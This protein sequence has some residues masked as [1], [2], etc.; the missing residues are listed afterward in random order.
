MRY[1]ILAV[2]FL[3]AFASMSAVADDAHTTLDM[4]QETA[5]I[6]VDMC[7]AFLSGYTR[8]RGTKNVQ[9]IRASMHYVPP[10]VINTVNSTVAAQQY[11]RV[12]NS[13]MVTAHNLHTVQKVEKLY[14]GLVLKR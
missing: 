5:T 10:Y 13:P 4:K 8:T 12:V 9:S 3:C 11:G 7:N 6:S 2:S 14:S 1:R